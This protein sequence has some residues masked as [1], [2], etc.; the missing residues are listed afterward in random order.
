MAAEEIRN[1]PPAYPAMSKRMGE[2]GRVDVKVLIDAQGMASKVEVGGSSGYPR[3][4]AAALE[5][6]SRWRFTP[7]RRNGVAE[8]M[9]TLVPINFK[10]DGPEPGPSDWGVKAAA[11]IEVHLHRDSALLAHVRAP[12]RFL[13]QILPDGSTTRRGV[14]ASSGAPEWDRQAALALDRV[15]LGPN[16]YGL[17]PREARVSMSGTETQVRELPG[18]QDYRQ[19][20]R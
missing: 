7:G 10:L 11:A 15:R 17:I 5:A 3:L 1:E 12:A 2:E 8:P 16:A 19:T 6:V 4:D 20:A 14:L 9:W 18:L 13:V